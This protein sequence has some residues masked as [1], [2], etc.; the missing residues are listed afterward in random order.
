MSNELNTMNV[1]PPADLSPETFEKRLALHALDIANAGAGN[2]PELN[3]NQA[4]TLELN[5][6]TF[7]KRA[8]G[9]RVY[10]DLFGPV[11]SELAHNDSNI[12]NGNLCTKRDE[13]QQLYSDVFGPDKSECV[14]NDANNENERAGGMTGM[15]KILS[16]GGTVSDS[17]RP[18][19]MDGMNKTA[20]GGGGFERPVGMDGM[21]KTPE[22]G[23]GVE[24]EDGNTLMRRR[25]IKTAVRRNTISCGEVSKDLRKNLMGVLQLGKDANKEILGLRACPLSQSPKRGVPMDIDTQ[26]STP[27]KKKKKES[28]K[29]GKIIDPSQKKITDVWAKN[30][31]NNK[32][33]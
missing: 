13:S 24:R 32:D 4:H 27:S 8:E 21:N 22:R 6:N 20:A 16:T 31:Q 25:M 26:E 28:R 9:R 5:M 23:G 7:A 10:S 14:H 15:N 11:Y 1:T 17:P 30:D 19:G 3:E 2:I 33:E 29:R 18:V 12:V